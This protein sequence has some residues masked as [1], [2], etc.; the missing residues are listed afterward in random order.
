MLD[1]D[2]FKDLNDT[3]GHDAGDVMLRDVAQVLA[4]NI[5]ASDV[6][7][8]FGGDE[9]IVL[10]PGA[11]PDGVTHKGRGLCE[12]VKVAGARCSMGVAV[13]PSDGVTGPEL[14]RSADAALYR[15]KAG[16]HSDL[17]L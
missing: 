2:K 8:R 6:A 17:T 10:L 14:I 9:F 1:I 16:H 4:A 3:R 11:S 12:A 5:R 7:C 15:D 13:F